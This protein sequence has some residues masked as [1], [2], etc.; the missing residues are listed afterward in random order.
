M[1]AD[2]ARLFHQE[3]KLQLAQQLGPPLS[4]ALEPVERDGS[5]GFPWQWRDAE[6]RFSAA[7]YRYVARRVRPG[8]HGGVVMDD[9]LPRGL[10]CGAAGPGLAA[11]AV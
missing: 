6:G 11:V 10:R 5:V 3:L 2:L 7:T 1:S 4:G 8:G 9:P